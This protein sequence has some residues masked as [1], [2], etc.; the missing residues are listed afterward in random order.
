MYATWKKREPDSF[1]KV[2]CRLLCKRSSMH[3]HEYIASED[4]VSTSSY[5]PSLS[6]Q[7]VV[8]VALVNMLASQLVGLLETIPPVGSACDE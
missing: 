5:G 6:L 2:K 1:S 3:G 8:A 7:L 4:V